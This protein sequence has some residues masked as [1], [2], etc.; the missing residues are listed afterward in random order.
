[1]T[2]SLDGMVVVITGASA[3]IGRML[4]EQLD[5]RGA[6]LVL[7]ARRLDALEQLN[8]SLGG[9]HLCVRADVSRQEDCEQLVAAAIQR[10]DRIDTLVCNAGF[11]IYRRIDQ[12]SFDEVRQL[13][14]TNVFG[15][16]DCIMSAM[17]HIRRQQP[18]DGW[19]GQ[20]M[21]VSS[22]AGRRGVPYIGMYSATK[23]A[24]LALADAL[25][26]EL[27]QDQIAVTGVFPVQTQ[28]DF[29]STAQSLGG[30]R[31]ASVT[32]FAQ[33][34]EHVA[35]RMLGAIERPCA[36]VWPSRPAKWLLGLGTVLP[37]LADRVMR[38]YLRRVE[39]ANHSDQ[40]K[41][42]VR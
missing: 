24:Q 2:R 25:R 5:Q 42:L 23:A 19:R 15:T 28:T 34:V 41:P 32:A 13:F 4:A 20:V 21:I 6:K 16:T 22:A 37:G 14:A 9:A 29:A 11:G 40:G 30:T 18:R 8:H 10:F 3:G 7:A 36:E 39:A 38:G 31:I 26:V 12:L 17:P 27:R 1:M 33:T 35:A